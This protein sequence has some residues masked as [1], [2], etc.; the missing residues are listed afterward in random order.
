M[1]TV[2]DDRFG[3]A[4]DALL[5][6]R[7]VLVLDSLADVGVVGC[8]A[9][10]VTEDVVNWMIRECR[11]VVYVG[12]PASRLEE[13]HIT[14]PLASGPARP[15][16]HVAV[17]A[18]DGVTTGISVPDRTRTIQTLASVRSSRT[19]FRIP[20]HVPTVA[21]S[22]PAGL[23]HVSPVNAL[24]HIEDVAG[25]DAGVVVCGVLAE[26]GPMATRRA[27]EEFAGRHGVPFLDVGDVLRA[28]R[29]AKGWETPW[30]GYYNDRLLDR[31]F[32][33]AIRAEGVHAV[34]N[35]LPVAVIAHCPAG[36]LF[37]AGCGCR[38]EL[39]AAVA[40][41]ESRGFG[42]VVVV[43]RTDRA[44]AQCPG[45]NSAP[46]QLADLVAADLA[47]AVAGPLLPAWS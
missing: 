23:A 17:D 4:R 43:R 45:P 40:A 26:E 2:T 36:H 25:L 11:G 1:T 24:A 34:A 38:A 18:L 41:V 32:E 15:R 44:M 13:L 5:A 9:S 6:G 14:A 31:P 19:D 16:V 20:G 27:L 7:P 28:Y 21:T 3:R 35:E 12:L 22:E 30:P 46:E 29:R 39:D 8:S 33:L 37:V 10:L 47:G 42:A